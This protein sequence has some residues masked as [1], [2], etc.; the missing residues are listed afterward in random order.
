VGRWVGKDKASGRG[1]MT[2][3][4]GGGRAGEL[5]KGLGGEDRGGLCR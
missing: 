2:D 1:F 3:W 4:G 5:E